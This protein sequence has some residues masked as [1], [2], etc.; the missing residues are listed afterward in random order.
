MARLITDYEKQMRDDL[1]EEA[2]D[3]YGSTV[4]LYSINREMSIASNAVAILYGEPGAHTAWDTTA[5]YYR[6][7]AFVNRPETDL[8]PNEGGLFTARNVE[9]SF[10]K[11]YLERENI[12]IPKSGDII[13]HLSFGYFDVNKVNKDGYYSDQDVD[14]FT[15]Y[16]CECARSERYT[17]DRKI[18]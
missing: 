18:D 13:Q 5:A 10:A 2:L 9:I 8:N 3:L 14:H 16:L 4:T 7:K 17:P 15:V 1:A 11:G 12:P 6:V